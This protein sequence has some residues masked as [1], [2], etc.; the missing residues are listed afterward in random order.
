[1][2]QIELSL[3]VSD[4]VHSPEAVT[5]LIEPSFS[6]GHDYCTEMF[7]GLSWLFACDEKA[8]SHVVQTKWNST[9]FILS[10]ES[11]L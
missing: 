5:N 1:M 7:N 11:P 9:K 8:S 6:P 10:L 4:D 2:H 3:S